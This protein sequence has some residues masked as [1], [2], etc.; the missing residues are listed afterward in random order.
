M[1]AQSLRSLDVAII[2]AG[3]A[4][5]VTA[6]ELI[7]AGHTVTIFEQGDGVGGVWVYTD[8]TEEAEGGEGEEGGAPP[9]P[10]H[11]SMYAGLRTNLPRHLM[12]FSD[13]PFGGGG[14]GASAYPGHGEVRAY[15]AAFAASAGLGAVIRRG[16]QVAACDPVPAAEDAAAGRPPL[17]WPRWRVT[18]GGGG[19]PGGEVFDALAVCSGHFAVPRRPPLDIDPSWGGPV[20]H[21]HDYRSPTAG[22]LGAALAKAGGE[23]VVAVLGAGPS[24]E[25][26][27]KE[28]SPHAATV[29][30]CASTWDADRRAPAGARG[31]IRAAPWVTGV[32]R[33]G[34]PVFEEAR[35]PPPAPAAGGAAPARPPPPPP[36]PAPPPPCRL[37]AL[38]LATGYRY[39]FPFLPAAAASAVDNEVRPH[40][41]DHLWPPAFAPGLSL[42]GLPF[43]VVPFPLMEA[44]AR[45][46]GAALS[47]RAPLPAD[48]AGRAAAQAADRAAAGIPARHAHCL[49]GRRQWAYIN[50]LAAAAAGGGGGGADC[51]D[52]GG[53]APPFMPPWRAALYD[54]ASAARKADPDGYR[55]DPASGVVVGEAAEAAAAWVEGWITER[56]GGGEAAEAV[57]ACEEGWIAERRGG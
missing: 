12:S 14:G 40:L 21:T 7:R 19:H 42:I 2:G 13:F 41:A 47:G 8:E 15:L 43:K 57:V 55:D 17:P 33:G 10:V 20:L 44:Q 25:D 52:G 28:I 45:R 53:A 29:L 11:S 22:R 30:L 4:G 37:A 18:A 46:V 24:G 1:A 27:A 9:P 38:V 32:G 54:A 35:L 16:A 26:V 5:L 23:G 48:L 51:G 50:G 3:A 34:V 6:R 36:P 31:N 49:S 56:R 39:A